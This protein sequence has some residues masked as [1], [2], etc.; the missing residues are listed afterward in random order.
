MST[1][2]TFSIPYRPLVFLLI[3]AILLVALVSCGDRRATRQA[4][5]DRPQPGAESTVQGVDPATPSSSEE[6]RGMAVNRIAYVGSDGNIFTIK[7]DG[8]DSRRLST[9]DF[10]VGPVG[11]I[12]S[13][14]AESQV[15]YAWPTWSPDG[16]KLAASRVTAEGNGVSFS[17]EVFDI[18]TGKVTTVY[19]NEPNTI[20]IAPGSPH[21]I[22]WSPNSENLTF[23][24]ST[25]T[26]LAL[27]IS[28]LGEGKQAARLLGEGPIFFSWAGDSS[29]LLMHRRLELLLAYPGMEPA[30]PIQS[31]GDVGGGFRAP[32]LSRDASKMV[33]A[34]GD[35][36]GSTLYLANTQ[37]ELA[38][39]SSI[40]DID[41][42][43]A[44]LWSPTRDEVAV[45]DTMDQTGPA[46]D[47][48]T[49][50]NTHGTPGTSLIN[51]PFLAFFWSPDGEKLVYV[52]FGSGSIPFTWKYVS[53]EEGEPIDL[54]KFLPSTDFLTII[55]F[56]D[57]YAYSNS[58]WSPDSSQIVFSGSLGPGGFSRNGGSNGG[59]KVYVLDVKENSS[60]R[61]IA[62]S[63]FAVWSWN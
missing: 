58:V 3:P 9:A 54:I 10:R 13:Q 48:L 23:I 62:T 28:K 55:S 17:L 34:S 60:P 37:S 7:P 12:L 51:E 36:A 44:F 21:Y 49:L 39:A 29:T 63:R 16:K 40:L 61:E 1:A 2:G 33:Y 6:E 24:A 52:A 19:D 32:A 53:R 26:E 14:G 59:A 22:Y 15:L 27:F 18:S 42:P 57:Q 8:T 35:E 41:F 4:G 5:P 25:P 43:S 50:I 56:F 38:G 30:R 31:L 47:R 11:H 20:P 46:F 45:A